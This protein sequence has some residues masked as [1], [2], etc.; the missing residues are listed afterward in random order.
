MFENMTSFP[1][2]GIALPS[3]YEGDSQSPCTFSSFWI[4]LRL[5]SS[6]GTM[7]VQV[8]TV[9]VQKAGYRTKPCEVFFNVSDQGRLTGSQGF[10]SRTTLIKLKFQ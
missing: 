4:P 8:F 1:E 6:L 10:T 2:Q 7:L 5:T 3:L 9:P